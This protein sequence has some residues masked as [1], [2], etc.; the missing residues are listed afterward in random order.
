MM[1]IGKNIQIF[2]PNNK[3]LRQLDFSSGNGAHQRNFLDAVK[4]H[5]NKLNAEIEI[6]HLSSSLC[7]LGNIVARTRRAAIFDPKTGRIVGD[8]EADKLIRRAY[9]PDHWAVPAG[10]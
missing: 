1:A 10:V 4:D 3:P 2:G 6:G 9:G 5:K 8:D 7:H